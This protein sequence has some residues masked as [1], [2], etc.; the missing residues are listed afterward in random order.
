MT[1]TIDVLK[2]D[3][4]KFLQTFPIKISAGKAS[5]L[6]NQVYY[7]K[8]GNDLRFNTG[9]ATVD[10]PATL[11]TCAAHIVQ[12]RHGDPDFYQLTDACDLMI[13]S[14][15]SGCC[16]ILEGTSRIAHVWPH[17]SKCQCTQKDLPL[18]SGSEVQDRLA[19]NYP[20][21][22]LYGIKN[23]VQ[24]YAYVIGVNDGNWKFYAQERPNDGPI[25]KAFRIFL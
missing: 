17:T 12:A 14:Q 3:P 7:G 2:A 24:T 25:K 13:T 11:E 10:D 23:Y 19:A 4:L 20:G 1:A 15:L 5:R 8:K 6:E 21:C 18:E 16:M 22:K 9:F